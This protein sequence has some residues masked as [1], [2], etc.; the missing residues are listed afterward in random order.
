MVEIPQHELNNL[1]SMD[2][3]EK[4]LEMDRMCRV[5]QTDEATIQAALA[6][7][8]TPQP[9]SPV[10]PSDPASWDTS[11]KEIPD[12]AASPSRP[13]LVDKQQFRF[14]YDPSRD[15][16]DRREQVAQAI[17]CSACGVALGIPDIR[18]IKVT[19]PSCMF[20]VTYT[21]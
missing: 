3:Y 4:M 9:A 2:G 11:Y 19:C 6:H 13:T 14:E 16:A 8:A 7:L 15:A 1:A 12:V 17:L 10:A 5:Y 21:D 20:E 18:P